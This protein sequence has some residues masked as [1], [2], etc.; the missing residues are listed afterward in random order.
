MKLAE[1]GN[2]ADAK[3]MQFGITINTSFMEDLKTACREFN[4]R[5]RIRQERAAE[6]MGVQSPRNPKS[7]SSQLSDVPEDVFDDEDV[8]VVDTLDALDTKVAT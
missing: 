7:D 8:M 5:E 6:R 4:E 3:K 1:S 2:N